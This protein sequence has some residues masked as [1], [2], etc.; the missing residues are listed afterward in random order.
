MMSGESADI[1]LLSF[2]KNEDPEP[3]LPG[4]SDGEKTYL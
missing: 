4:G 2:Q 3:G 1:Y